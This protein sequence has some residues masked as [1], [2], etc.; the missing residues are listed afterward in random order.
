VA[1]V[2]DRF[3]GWMWLS[4]TSHRDPWSGLHIRLAPDEAYAYAMRAEKADRHLGIAAVLVSRLLSDVRG[5]R[6]ISRVY[7]WVDRRNRESQTLLRMM[8]GFKQVQRV[9]RLRTLRIGWQVPWSDDPKFG[10]VSRVGRHSTVAEA[11]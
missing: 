4:R 3:A 1:T 5:D 9:R 6:A 7:G 11:E 10:P 2:D 8:F